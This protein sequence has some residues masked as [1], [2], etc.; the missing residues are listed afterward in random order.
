MS[1]IKIRPKLNLNV[2]K[3]DAENFQNQTLRPILKL[4][5]DIILILFD[6]QINSYKLS[7]PIDQNS[8]R[9][10]IENFVQKNKSLNNQLIGVIIGM[11]ENDEVKEY[12][13]NSKEFNKRII[14]MIFTAIL[15][16][17]TFSISP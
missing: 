15:W 7:L 5:N 12:F 1:K 6:K 3:G 9:I 16:T 10:E 11:M 14:Q 17:Y 4:Q 2:S 13:K 8:L